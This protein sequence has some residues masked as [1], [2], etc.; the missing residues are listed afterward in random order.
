M[1]N[2]EYAAIVND[3]GIWFLVQP[4][5]THVFEYTDHAK[6]SYKYVGWQKPLQMRNTVG[7]IEL[8]NTEIRA[9]NPRVK[10]K[11][12]GKYDK[13]GMPSIICESKDILT[14]VNMAGADGW[15]ITGG[16]G[17]ADGY[18]ADNGP[19]KHETKW[20]MMRREL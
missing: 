10:G 9:K 17:L 11:K 3:L 19:G 20:R 8:M 15:E 16:L 7:D 1:A 5:E 12:I 14:L 2:W 4:G 6:R 13:K 18:P